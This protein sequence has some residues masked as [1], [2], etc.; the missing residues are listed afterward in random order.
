MI[1][2][3]QSQSLVIQGYLQGKLRDKISKEI[4]M[5]TGTVSNIV[6]D[7]KNRIGIPVAEELRNFVI[8]VRKSGISIGQCIEG[9]RMFQLMKNLGITDDDDINGIQVVDAV[10][11]DSN[12]NDNIDSNRIITIKIFLL[13]YMRSI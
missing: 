8:G 11:S 5:S 13:L 1:I 12:S 2:S 10:G 4:G 7:W 3:N 9:Y 6:K